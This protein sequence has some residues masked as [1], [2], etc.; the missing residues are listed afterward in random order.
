MLEMVAQCLLVG[1]APFP[2]R[3]GYRLGMNI[4]AFFLGLS[5]QPLRRSMKIDHSCRSPTDRMSRISFKFG[6]R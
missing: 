2:R 6:K 5:A 4:D 1:H 3:D